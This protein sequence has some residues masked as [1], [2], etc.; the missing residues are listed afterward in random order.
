MKIYYDDYEPVEKVYTSFNDFCEALRKDYEESNHGDK[1]LEEWVK[2]LI[3]DEHCE[4][5]V[6]DDE[7]S[8]FDA[9]SGTVFIWI[10]DLED[11]VI[12][13]D[14]F[15][16]FL[17]RRYNPSEIFFMDDYRREEIE[18]DFRERMWDEYFD[19]VRCVYKI[20]PMTKE[21]KECFR[22]EDLWD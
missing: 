8:Y 18:Q 4:H 20:Y 1:T 16:A 15:P 6:P 21:V 9:E 22:Y 5:E 2:S 14:D 3:D 12:D 19:N 17:D 10:E 7:P 11:Y 13:W